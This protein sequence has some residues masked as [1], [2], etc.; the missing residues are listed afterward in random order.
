MRDEQPFDVEPR[1][2]AD[3]P[4]SHDRIAWLL[5]LAGP[6]PEV[7][8]ERAARVHARVHDQWRLATRSRRRRRWLFAFGGALAAAAALAALFLLPL[9][10][11][12][13]GEPPANAPAPVEVARVETLS[14]AAYETAAT[15]ALGP[16]DPMLAEGRILWSGRA[17]ETGGDG[18][19]ALRLGD[20]TSIRLDRD[21]RLRL[22]GAGIFEL[23][24]G[25]VYV[26]SGGELRGGRAAVEIHT[27]FGVVRDV[28][29]QFE[30]RTRQDGLRVRVREGLVNVGR[31]DDSWEARAGGELRLAGDGSIARAEIPIFGPTWSWVLE[32]APP[33]DLEGSTLD[34]FLAWAQRETGWQ[35]RFEGGSTAASAGAIVL[36]GAVEDL[37]PDQAIDVVLPTCGLAYRLQDGSLWIRPE[38]RRS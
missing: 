3:A 17:V 12:G 4:E 13:A 36:H 10:G 31:Q 24:R 7:P 16:L 2:E 22:A 38:P 1:G 14:G 25:A 21:S 6:R 26:D 18:R 11:P 28:G 32:I 5:R 23:E 27:N 30:V 33:F 34:E 35:V 15:T 9:N 20:G 8:A 37:P 29:T 19:A